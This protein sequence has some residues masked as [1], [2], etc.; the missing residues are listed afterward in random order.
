MAGWLLR[1][2]IRGKVSRDRFDSLE[3]ACAELE[4]RADEQARKANAAPEGGGLMRRIDPV[5]QVV[6]RLE[7]AGP[8]RRRG[9]V[10]VRGDGS[11][12]AWTG[13]LRRDLVAQRAGESPAEALR[14]ALT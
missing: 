5:Q 14:R 7:R 1:E 11:S 8:G 13:R 3:A 4:A 12:E 6:A 10:D 2:R 9:G